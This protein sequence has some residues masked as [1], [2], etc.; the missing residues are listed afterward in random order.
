MIWLTDRLTPSFKTIADFRWDSGVGIRNVDR[1][2]ALRA[3]TC[4]YSRKRL[5]P[6]MGKYACCFVLDNEGECNG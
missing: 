1:R 5:L 2:F 3:M 4:G 6:S